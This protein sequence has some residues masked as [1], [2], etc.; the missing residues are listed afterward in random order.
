MGDITIVNAPRGL[1]V[2][3]T[4]ISIFLKRDKDKR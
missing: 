2:V 3:D 1:I 4:G